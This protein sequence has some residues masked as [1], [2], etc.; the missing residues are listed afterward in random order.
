MKQC[1]LCK[2]IVTDESECP[3]CGNT[4]TYEPPVM[5]DKELVVWNKY[6]F[7]YY[8]KNMWFSVLSCIIGLVVCIATKPDMSYLFFAGVLCA[9]V[10]LFISVFH[11]YL[12][13]YMIWKYSGV[14]VPYKL[15]S[16]KYITG[17]IAILFFICA[18]FLL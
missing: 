13:K 9:L 7:M 4:I 2:S 15:G 17:G 11:R 1:P 18:G 8:L 5:A 14:Y 3:I 6:S 10:S 12:V 16:L